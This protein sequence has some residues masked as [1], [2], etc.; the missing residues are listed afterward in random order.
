[1]INVEFELHSDCIED[2]EEL[3]NVSIHHTASTVIESLQSMQ[4]YE[5]ILQKVQVNRQSNKLQ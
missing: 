3:Q 5:D 1:M 4:Q 2:M